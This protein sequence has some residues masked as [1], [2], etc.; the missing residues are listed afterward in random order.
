MINR[1]HSISGLVRGKNNE[2]NTKWLPHAKTATHRRH[3][4]S[5]AWQKSLAICKCM[6]QSET[7]LTGKQE[8]KVIQWPWV[9]IT[10]AFKTDIITVDCFFRCQS[11]KHYV[12]W[13]RS[14]TT[15]HQLLF[16]NPHIA[17][18]IS[19][20]DCLEHRPECR[21]IQRHSIPKTQA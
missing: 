19:A 5:F 10:R 4:V 21:S 2:R 16:C 17:Y 7:V 13:L 14:L 18:I 9:T 1:G 12:A 20:N 6:T 3:P 15:G 8:N 11:I